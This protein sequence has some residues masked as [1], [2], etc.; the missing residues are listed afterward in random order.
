ML[1]APDNQAEKEEFSNSSYINHQRMISVI[2]V[3]SATLDL[4]QS[5]FSIQDFDSKPNL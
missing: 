1:R 4:E 5:E 2:S 3:L